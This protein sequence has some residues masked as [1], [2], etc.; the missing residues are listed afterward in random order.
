MKVSSV[1][2]VCEV[3]G[4]EVKP[5]QDRRIVVESHWS[6]RDLVTLVVETGT[7]ITISADEL[8][9]AL[10]NAQNAHKGQVV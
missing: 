3:N 9:R 8:G 1:I 2:D 10:A 6:R 7:S 5:G 4:V